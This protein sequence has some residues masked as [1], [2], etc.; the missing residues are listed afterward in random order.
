M[1]QTFPF[2]CLFVFGTDEAGKGWRKI[3]L[4]MECEK[5]IDSVNSMLLL[6]VS[7]VLLGMLTNKRKLASPSFTE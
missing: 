6:K 2:I 5:S 1:M 7:G 3:V 4:Q